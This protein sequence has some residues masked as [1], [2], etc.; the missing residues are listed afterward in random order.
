MMRDI[1]ESFA[2]TTSTFRPNGVLDDWA[3]DAYL[4]V[5]GNAEASGVRKEQLLATELPLAAQV[6][7]NVN[8]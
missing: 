6:A 4:C 7:I 1:I 3:G 2:K 5:S 8:K